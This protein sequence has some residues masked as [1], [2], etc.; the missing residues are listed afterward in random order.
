MNKL[1]GKKSSTK[2]GKVM[3]FLAKIELSICP[4]TYEFFQIFFEFLITPL[5]KNV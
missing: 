5:S 4:N 3:F 1:A 2:T